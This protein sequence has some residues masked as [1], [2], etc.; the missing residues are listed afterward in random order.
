VL[1]APRRHRLSV[2]TSPFQGGKTGSIPV[3]AIINGLYLQAFF[4]GQSATVA[5]RLPAL[6]TGADSLNP[7]P[8]EATLGDGWRDRQKLRNMTLAEADESVHYS[9][10]PILEALLEVFVVP[11]PPDKLSS[12]DR[13]GTEISSDYPEKIVRGQFT[14][15]IMAGTQVGATASQQNDGFIFKSQDGKQQL[16]VHLN[17]FAFH[18]LTPYESWEP[19]FNEARRLWDLYVDAVGNLTVVRVGVRYI[20]QL[21]FPA[22]RDLAEFL[23]VY[24]L[25]DSIS[26]ALQGYGMT[27]QIPVPPNGLLML[28]EALLPLASPETSRVLLDLQLQFPRDE[29]VGLWD[30]I[31]SIRPIKNRIFNECLTEQMK[32]AIA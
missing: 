2:R 30:Q 11:L 4:I 6:L 15:Q 28:Q 10:A 32:E 5:I 22:G 3:G 16:Q 17:G 9:K 1:K 13:L 14:A 18:R 20:N 26:P 24:P 8:A 7:L 12:L 31:E 25:T 27:A 23:K 19:F 29:S 21:S